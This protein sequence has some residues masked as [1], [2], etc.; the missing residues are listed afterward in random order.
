MNYKLDMKASFMVKRAVIV[1][2]ITILMLALSVPVLFASTSQV[3]VQASVAGWSTVGTASFQIS[4]QNVLSI[5]AGASNFARLRRTFVLEQNTY[6]RF[7]A[8]VRSNATRAHNYG[9]NIYMMR[10]DGSHWERADFDHSQQNTWQTLSFDFNTGNSASVVIGLQQGFYWSNYAFGLTEFRNLRLERLNFSTSIDTHWRILHVVPRHIDARNETNLPG[11]HRIQVS[12]DDNDIMNATNHGNRFAQSL[13]TNSNNQMTAE[14]TTVVLEG[15]ITRFEAMHWGFWPVRN[16][17]PALIINQGINLRD[18]D[19]VMIT[20][21]QRHNATQYI[22]AAAGGLAWRHGAGGITLGYTMQWFDWM[23]PTRGATWWNQFGHP[24]AYM[25]EMMH[26]LEHYGGTGNIV[27]NAFDFQLNDGRHPPHHYQSANGYNLFYQ[28]FMRRQLT[29]RN[30]WHGSW[31]GNPGQTNFG[32]PPQA[33]QRVR[34]TYSA[35]INIFQLLFLGAEQTPDATINFVN[36]TLTGLVG[37]ATYR[38]MIGVVELATWTQG[39]GNTTRNIENS[40]I[41]G[42][43]QLIRVG[44]GV[45]TVDS[46]PQTINFPVRPTVP[47]PTANNALNVDGTGSLSN[48]TTVHEWRI[49]GGTWAN[50]VGSNV[51]NLS[52]GTYE[53]R[54]RATAT[55][56]ASLTVIRNIILISDAQQPIINTHPISTTIV[57]GQNIM[58]AIAATITDG[59]ILSY[60][61]YRSEDQT[62]WVFTNIVGVNISPDATLVGTFYYRVV[63]T[64]TNANVNG[65]QTVQVTSNIAVVTISDVLFAPT[66]TRIYTATPTIL[67]WGMVAGATGYHIY[68]AGARV[69]TTPVTGTTFDLGQLGLDVGQH[70]IQ[71]R[72]IG[73][74]ITSELGAAVSFFV[75]EVIPDDDFNN[76]F[77]ILGGIGVLILLAAVISFLVQR[78]RKPA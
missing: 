11:Q 13:A 18:F 49:F 47:N 48:V 29:I 58:L 9:A 2:G 69:T 20:L 33:F 77:W 1:C 43:R 76:T 30:T 25:H 12:I 45:T 61:W 8:E 6:H 34:R 38:L 60:R 64:N 37:G 52:V 55:S 17:I 66:D 28:Q 5:N 78:K 73:V 50:V 41:G 4:P 35:S 62:T 42:N 65:I 72:A 46:A 57:V 63:V 59:G 44:N 40:W 71:V 10:G 56:F 39:M 27:D 14:V 31:G 21:R 22:P 16:Q 15:T 74:G 67:R 7:T 75:S 24:G 23:D 70:N 54:V 36:E 19:K 51:P 53:I 3:S 26:V 68:V 32:L